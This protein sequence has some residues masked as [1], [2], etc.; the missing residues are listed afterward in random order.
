M[1][2]ADLHI[3]IYVLMVL[4]IS[5]VFLSFSVQTFEEAQM[6]CLDYLLMVQASKSCERDFCLFIPKLYTFICRFSLN[7]N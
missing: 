2:L 5:P 1:T 7:E 3:S 6:V 4:S